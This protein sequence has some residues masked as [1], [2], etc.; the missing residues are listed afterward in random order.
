LFATLGEGTILT[1]NSQL[2]NRIIA[3]A[4]FVQY[5]IKQYRNYPLFVMSHYLF[6]FVQHNNEPLPLIS[7]M[8]AQLLETVHLMNGIYHSKTLVKK[9][10]KSQQKFSFK[11]FEKLGLLYTKSSDEDIKQITKVFYLLIP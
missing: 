2:T 7:G 11:E 3:D 8:L 9:I 10:E 5:V 1:H 6:R 4:D